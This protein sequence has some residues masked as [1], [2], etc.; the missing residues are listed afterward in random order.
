MS[1]GMQQGLSGHFNKE[2]LTNLSKAA[3]DTDAQI[4]A[5]LTPEQ[6]AAFPASQQDE[7]AHTAGLA[8]NSE[9]VGMQSTLELTR[10]QMDSVYAALYEL[11]FNQLTSSVEPKFNSIGDQMRWTLDEKIKALTP[12]LTET[13]LDQ[14][15][16][17]QALQA[18]VV[19]DM[20]KKMEAS[21]IKTGN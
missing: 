1:A 5:L 17:Q 8:A 14:Y 20:V 12:L 18:K 9:L 21:G 10:E 4:K 16:Q 19:K 7:A 15:R 11:N 6:L 13:Q 2:E 3:G